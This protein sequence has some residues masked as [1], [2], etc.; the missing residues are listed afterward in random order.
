MTSDAS[1][2]PSTCRSDFVPTAAIIG[3]GLIGTSV[4]LGLRASGWLVTGWDPDPAAVQV[5]LELAAIDEQ[6]VGSA[7]AMQSADLV[8]LAGPPG[9]RH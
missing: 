6:A 4:G 8:V 5:A 9:S 7:E 2:L 3:T 1:R